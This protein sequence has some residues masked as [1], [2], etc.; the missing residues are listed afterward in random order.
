M[1]HSPRPR[2]VLVPKKLPVNLNNNAF[3]RW[4]ESHSEL[5]I[6]ILHLCIPQRKAFRSTTRPFI[7][8]FLHNGDIIRITSFDG[9]Y[10]MDEISP[11]H[12]ESITQTSTGLVSLKCPSDNTA[13]RQVI[14][15]LLSVE[16]V[17]QEEVIIPWAVTTHMASVNR[18]NPLVEVPD[19]RGWMCESTA[20]ALNRIL[21]GVVRSRSLTEGGRHARRGSEEEYRK[22]IIRGRGIYEEVMRVSWTPPAKKDPRI[23]EWELVEWLEEERRLMSD[24]EMG[25]VNKKRGI[26]FM[27]WLRDTDRWMQRARIVRQLERDERRRRIWRSEEGEWE[28]IDMDDS[29]D[30]WSSLEE[31]SL[32]SPRI[33]VEM[34]RAN[35]WAERTLE[36]M[37]GSG[38]SM[39]E[40]YGKVDP[41]KV[42]PY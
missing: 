24:E 33:D 12:F 29:E 10:L 3:R 27:A 32:M 25:R 17:I 8:L 26:G 28:I 22:G 16:S 7:L 21:L 30:D 5:Y 41:A 6:D 15:S 11:L 31:D 18:P 38:S 36:S 35:E 9:D 39:V 14:T 42:R 1:S 2:S 23:E 20:E 4:F 13:V 37:F 40:E 19:I 34:P